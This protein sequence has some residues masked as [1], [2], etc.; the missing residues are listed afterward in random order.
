MGGATNSPA[1]W[2]F[3]RSSRSIPRPG[4]CAGAYGYSAPVRVTVPGAPPRTDVGFHAVV[5]NDADGHDTALKAAVTDGMKRALRSFGDR[6]GNCL[7]GDQSIR[8]AAKTGNGTAPATD[9]SPSLKETIYELGALGGFD[10]GKVRE[11]VKAK[12][13]KGID[14]LSTEQLMSLVQAATKRLRQLQEKTEEQKAA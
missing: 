10:D 3:G 2:P 14:E 6:F 4:R 12:E 8:P 9:L 13:G 5:E 7:Y 11:A 1:T